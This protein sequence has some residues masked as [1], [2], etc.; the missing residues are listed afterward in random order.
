MYQEYIR[1]NIVKETDRAFMVEQEVNNRRDGW[2]TKY[3]W[4]AKSKC[5]DR[6]TEQMEVCGTLLKKDTVLVPEWLVGNG[7]W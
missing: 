6:Q 1:R 2:K 4:V 7:V 5:K 3:K